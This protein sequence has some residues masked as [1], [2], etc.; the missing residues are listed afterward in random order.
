[1]SA[2]APVQPVPTTQ[3]SFI[4]REHR[5][6]LCKRKRAV[7]DDDGQELESPAEDL[8]HDQM[9]SEDTSSEDNDSS[10]ASDGRRLA[11]AV[12]KKD[13]YYV[14]GH[15]RSKPL[16]GGN[17]PHAAPGVQASGKQPVTAS[18]EERLAD[19]DLF[20]PK[21]LFTDQALSLKSR[22]LSNLTAILHQCMLN[23]DWTRANRVWAILL[24]IEVGGDGIDI[25]KHGRWTIGAELLMKRHLTQPA[26]TPQGDTA[27]GRFIAEEGFQLARAYYDRLILQ[28]PHSQQ[29]QHSIVTARAIYPALFN[30]WIYGIQ[31]AAKRAREKVQ[32]KSTNDQT[33]SS[34]ATSSTS[35]SDDSVEEESMIRWPDDHKDF[36]RMRDIFLHEL[37]EAQAV[38]ARLDEL[39]LSPTY[40]KESYLRRLQGMVALWRADI[41]ELIADGLERRHVS[42]ESDDDIGEADDDEYSIPR[43]RE[44]ARALLAIADQILGGSLQ[45]QRSMYRRPKFSSVLK[46]DRSVSDDDHK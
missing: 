45:D 24:R 7:D 46:E 11:Q 14:A 21:S 19:L 18:I 38:A 12:N 28:Y 43:H 34:D 29:M 13:P 22:H 27:A 39:M 30:V 9:D 44:G 20:L 40:D 8:R 36:S 26:A 37:E 3:Q 5:R 33:P 10:D 25:R 23:E 16:P 17:F 4:V 6:L 42:H 1:M 15:P 31:D 2:F 32:L 41:H 35:S